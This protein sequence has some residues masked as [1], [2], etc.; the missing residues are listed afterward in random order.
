[1]EA[2]VTMTATL[3]VLALV[4]MIA[5]SLDISSSLAIFQILLPPKTLVELE[6]ELLVFWITATLASFHIEFSLVF[7][8][9]LFQW[10]GTKTKNKLRK[11]MVALN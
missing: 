7:L 6:S 8:N 1:M 11:Q 3:M 10:E 9:D 2:T 5:I 4:V